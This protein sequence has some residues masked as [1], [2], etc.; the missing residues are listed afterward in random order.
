MLGHACFHET[1][2][3]VIAG[4]L[5]VGVPAHSNA[6]TGMV[7]I[8]IVKTNF[9]VGDAAAIGTL[10]FHDMNYELTIGGIGAVL[11]A[12]AG[13][14][15]TGA[16]RNLQTVTDVAGTYGAINGEVTVVG[17]KVLARLRNENDVVLELR[18]VELDIENSI[19]LAGMIIMLRTQKPTGPSEESDRC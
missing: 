8:K 6:E 16:A 18:G 13:G 10:S 1:L 15:L 19:D 11:V 17:G 4:L 14:R 2:S 5:V 12:M 9:V 3:A 7:C